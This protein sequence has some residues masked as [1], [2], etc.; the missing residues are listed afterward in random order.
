METNLGEGY[1]YLVGARGYSAYEIAQ[2][3]GFTGTEEE[4]LASLVGPQGEKGTPFG[5][6]TPEEKEQIRG[7]SAYEVAVEN[8][9]IGTVDDWINAF[10][11][12]DGYCQTDYVDNLEETKINKKPYYYNSVSD[13]KADTVL[14]VGDLCI[15]TGYYSFNDGGGATYKVREKTESDVAD[16]GF[17]HIVNNLVFELLIENNMVN[18][19]QLGA[20]SLD[21][22]NT[23]EDIV[24]YVQKYITYLDNSLNQISLYIPSG[25]WFSSPLNIARDKGFCITGDG[26]FTLNHKECSTYITSLNDN[27]E[28]IWKI[29][30]S[31]TSCNNWVLNNIYFSSSDFNY[32]TSIS[33]GVYKKITDACLIFERASF[34]LSDNLFFDWIEGTALKIGSSWENYFGLLNFRHINALGKSVIVIDDALTSSD[35]VT[36]TSFEKIMCESSL[37]DFILT[38]Q[39]ANFGNSYIGTF[40]F[41]AWPLTPSSDYVFTTITTETESDFTHWS[42]FNV[43]GRCEIEVNNLELNNFA[44][45]YLTYNEE[46]YC[47]DT[48]VNV[49]EDGANPNMVI[50]NI[51]LSGSKMDFPILRQNNHYLLNTNSFFVNN[52][53]FNRTT[54]GVYFDVQG[55]RKIYCNTPVLN[56]N[57]SR[58]EIYSITRL[59][60]VI[61]FYEVSNNL[62]AATE[63]AKY[64][65]LYY[66]KDSRNNLHLVAKPY[67]TSSGD[68]DV[69]ILTSNVICTGDNLLIRAKVPAETSVV[70]FLMLDNATR[71][72]ITLAG[73]GDYEDYTFTGINATIPMGKIMSIRMSPA[74]AGL[75]CYLDYYKFY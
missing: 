34:G 10:L 63:Q 61:P 51:A 27:Q 3:H 59:S 35:N 22:N 55:A 45:R 17:Y 56:A 46:K 64:G 39:N 15:T 9:F 58:S 12:P 16:N 70:L 41:E 49:L 50:N 5:E 26:K 66:D 19:K 75:D 23:K 54:F 25:V 53:R 43:E 29:G 42:L 60:D 47:Y 48:I 31:T 4:W 69:H 32:S 11:T 73:T 71:K 18:I 2:Q 40:N 20:K 38:K 37:G 62:T 52:I 74:S 8:G 28:Y 30:N 1:L 67:N 13:M 24:P 65:V 68:G 6:L 36:A 57:T 33:K 21:K 7:K 44:F 14:K 72:N